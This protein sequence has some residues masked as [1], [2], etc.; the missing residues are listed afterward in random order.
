[1]KIKNMVMPV[2]YENNTILIENE[3]NPKKW[4]FFKK[5][6]EQLKYRYKYF[7]QKDVK[8]PTKRHPFNPESHLSTLSHH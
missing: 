1:V 2:R 5:S 8:S 6:Q 3:I 4:H 7:Y